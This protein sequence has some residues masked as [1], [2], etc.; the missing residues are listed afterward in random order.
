MITLEKSINAYNEIFQTL[1]KHKD[2]CAFDLDELKITSKLHIFGLELKEKYGF[3]IEPKD[4]H[5]LD[6]IKLGEYSNISVW[7]EKSGRTISYPDDGRQPEN[8]QLLYI[9]FPTGA[10]IFGEDY[11]VDLFNRFF[12]E[13]KSYNPKYIDS[14]NKG[15]YFSMDNAGNAFNNLAPTLKKYMD[16]CREELVRRRIIAL[17]SELE[18]L[19]NL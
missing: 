6:W 3:D 18:G 15:L 13:L 7:G 12:T 11:P 8:E 5:S 19:E 16:V 17:K 14:S 10:Y 4:I 2:V 1:E 9:S